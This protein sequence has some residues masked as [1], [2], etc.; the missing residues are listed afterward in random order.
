MEDH[1]AIH[2]KIHELSMVIHH[3][4]KECPCSVAEASFFHQAMARILGPMAMAK[5]TVATG[6][7]KSRDARWF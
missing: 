4:P 6:H 1:H 3:F 5:P 7:K 2:G